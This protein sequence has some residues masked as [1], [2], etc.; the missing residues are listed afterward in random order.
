MHLKQQDPP[1]GLSIP[2]VEH[3]IKTPL[4]KTHLLLLFASRNVIVFFAVQLIYDG[5]T[6]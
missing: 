4:S 2:S 6:K 1:I 3:T 5:L